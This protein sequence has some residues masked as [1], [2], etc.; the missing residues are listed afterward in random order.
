MNN[1]YDTNHTTINM[2]RK[3]TGKG[4]GGK[5]GEKKS[6]KKGGGFGFGESDDAVEAEEPTRR[7]V[8]QIDLGSRCT[9][10]GYNCAGTI[11]FVGKD[12]DG[13][14]KVG[15]E[16]DQPIGKNN[17]TI[18]GKAYFQCAPNRGVMT[19]PKKVVVKGGGLR[20]LMKSKYV[21]WGLVLFDVIS[22][23]LELTTA[24]DLSR[25]VWQWD[26]DPEDRARRQMGM[27]PEYDDWGGPSFA[28][29]AS[30]DSAYAERFIEGKG[31]ETLGFFT[32]GY[33]ADAT[34]TESYGWFL[35]IVA[36]FSFV[37][38]DILQR[39]AVHKMKQ[40]PDRLAMAKVWMQDPMVWCSCWD[41]ILVARGSYSI[42][43]L[44][45]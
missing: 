23:I 1:M 35:I 9:V 37:T 24:S 7:A 33:G 44:M 28:A 22:W 8:T 16:L 34:F 38:V 10:D 30:D 36:T 42:Q 27:A 5:Q 31:V 14:Q 26:Y 45:A 40:H 19:T 12:K 25:S 6:T 32:P 15:V 21:Y 3:T 13:K 18:K 4:G 20:E 29:A 11:R 39:V 17:G 2:G 43:R 41:E